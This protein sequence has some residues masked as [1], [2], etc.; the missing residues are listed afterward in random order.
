MYWDDAVTLGRIA[1]AALEA[2][3]T[4]RQSLISLLHDAAGRITAKLAEKRYF[5]AARQV[6]IISAGHVR[7]HRSDACV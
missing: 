4:T 7:V 2:L 5:L 1:P 3:P 6:R